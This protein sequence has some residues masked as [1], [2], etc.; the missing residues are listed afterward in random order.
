MMYLIEV[1]TNDE[2]KVVYER[3]FINVPLHVVKEEYTLLSNII[4]LD[5]H[6]MRMCELD[7]HAFKN[8][9]EIIGSNDRF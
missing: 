4:D 2:G 6:D 7:V 5:K 9:G 1:L 8:H 3:V